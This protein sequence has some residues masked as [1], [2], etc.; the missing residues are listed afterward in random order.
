VFPT[1]THCGRPRA[2]RRRSRHIC[3]ITS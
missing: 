2:K 3:H 1:A